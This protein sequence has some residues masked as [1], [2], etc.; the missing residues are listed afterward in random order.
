MIRATTA[1]KIRPCQTTYPYPQFIKSLKLGNDC[2]FA[3]I[4][5]KDSRD[6][7]PQDVELVCKTV[8]KSQHTKI[9]ITHGTYTMPDTAKYLK[10]N[11]KRKD[12]TII[13]TGS[14]IPIHGF[15]SSDGGFNLGYAVA[16][17]EHLP[18]G[19]YLCMNGQVFEA[20]KVKKNVKEG[21]FEKD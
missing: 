13:L 5:M 4:C 7:T 3:E 14:L 20:G 18:A 16:Q 9:I 19:V 21:R 15:S 1:Q 11:L 2:D 8:E 10:E 12:Q 17:L 6:L